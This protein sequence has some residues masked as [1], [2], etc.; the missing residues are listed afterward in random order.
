MVAPRRAL[1]HRAARRWEGLIAPRASGSE[2]VEGMRGEDLATHQEILLDLRQ[3]RRLGDVVP[4][5]LDGGDQMVG[6]VTGA[7]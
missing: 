4:G 5:L 2:A 3:P 1:L 6:D 7:W